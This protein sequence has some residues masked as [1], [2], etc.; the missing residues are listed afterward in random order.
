MRDQD[1]EPGI[2]ANTVE[3]V[4]QQRGLSASDLSRATGI[5]RSTLSLL[6]SGK[7]SD[8][9]TATAAK[10]SHA[11]GVSVDYLLGL[12]DKPEPTPL[13][14]GEV[15]L[16]LV[17]V[18]RHLPPSRQRDLLLIARAYAQDGRQD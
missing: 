16:E 15:L 3:E 12:S 7:R 13:M 9:T 1:I 17:Q 4:M 8:T 11:L 6:L 14:L 2:I 5:S 18:A 10:I